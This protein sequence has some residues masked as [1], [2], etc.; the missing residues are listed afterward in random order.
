MIQHLS[1]Q[2]TENNKVI[3]TQNGAWHSALEFLLLLTSA[4]ENDF[5]RHFHN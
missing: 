2:L 4:G 5:H 3:S 1:L